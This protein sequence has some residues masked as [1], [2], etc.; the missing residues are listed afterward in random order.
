MNERQGKNGGGNAALHDALY[1]QI[2]SSSDEAIN[3]ALGLVDE[4]DRTAQKMVAECETLLAAVRQ[5]TEQIRSELR[6]KMVEFATV[7]RDYSEEIAAKNRAYVEAARNTTD[8]I[9][10]HIEAVRAAMK[11]VV[12]EGASTAAHHAAIIGTRPALKQ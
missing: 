9:S 5:G 4:A 3:V 6:E 8:M 12:H 2:T 1:Q 10:S 7:M 11:A